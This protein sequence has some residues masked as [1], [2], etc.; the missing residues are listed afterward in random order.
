MRIRVKQAK[1]DTTLVDQE[2]SVKGWVRTVRNQKTF[3]F[4]E[5]NDG[6][7]LS[8]LQVIVDTDLPNYQ[9]LTQQLSTGCAVAVIGLVK[10]SPGK[11]QAQ[12]LHARSVEITGSC[13][14]T[15]YPLQKKR[16]TFEF[17]RTIAHLRPRTNT[18]GAV[19][20][21]RNALAYATHRFFQERGFL[22]INTPV[23]TASDC[24]G[25]GE[26]FQVTTLDL[27]NP[28]LTEEKQIDYSQDFFER[29]AFLT[30]S[31]QLNGEIFASA[32]SD[33]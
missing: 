23:I 26:M 2:I 3:S 15:V 29:P 16:H 27:K 28:P 9:Q 17:L 33:I 19:S 30:V 1:K 22:Y 4:I 8:N 20:R 7:C 12:E 5:I 11:G 21:V 31:G 32:L 25:A 24:E 14:P 18:F 13:D 10:E 6:S